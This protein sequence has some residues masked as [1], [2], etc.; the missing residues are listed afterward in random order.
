MLSFLYL[1]GNIKKI[2]RWET[3][4]FSLFYFLIFFGFRG[5]IFFDVFNY[6]PFFDNI[7][8]LIVMIKT[9]YHKKIFFWEPGFVYYCGFFK[10]FTKN[11]FVFQFF[12]TL[13]NFILLH[14]ALRWFHSEDCLNFMIIIA[15][16]GLI[17]F[18]E[19][20]RNTKAILILFISLRYIYTRNIFKYIFLW[21]IALSFHLSS[22]IFFPVY[23]F[24][25]RKIPRMIFFLFGFVAMLF[26]FWGKSM[27]IYLFSFIGNN[28]DGKFAS[29][30]NNYALAEND[31]SLQRLFSLGMA[32]KI[33]TFILVIW[34]YNKI[35]KKEMVLIVNTFLVYFFLY[36]VFSGFNEV[37][38]RL[39]ML[40][41]FSYWV[42]WPFFLREVNLK[43]VKFIFFLCLLL[44][45]ILKCSLY[46][47][48]VQKYDNILFG[49]ANNYTKREAVKN[50][51]N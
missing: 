18:I 22:I 48:P 32:E 3:L 14:I 34:F 29:Y 30:I 26:L 23:F 2:N 47:Q 12:D 1:Y 35:Y 15:M 24:L 27:L 16:S 13:L 7:P 5:F 43:S 31:Y 11:Y 10:L 19:T 4:L 6:K 49:G 50:F 17:M 44:Y 8:D 33:G 39:S 20:L 41:V 46:S 42:L 51:A 37:S 36:F 21:L 38:N 9:A 28:I 45:S 40:F 25:S